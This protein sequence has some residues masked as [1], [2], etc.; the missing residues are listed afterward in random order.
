MFQLNSFSQVDR[1]FIILGL[2]RWPSSQEHWLLFQDTQV[3]AGSSSDSQD[4][5]CRCL[6]LLSQVVPCPF[7]TSTGTRLASSAYTYNH[8][9]KTPRHL[10]CVT[11]FKTRK[12]LSFLNHSIRKLFSHYVFLKLYV[13]ETFYFPLLSNFQTF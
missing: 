2:E 11:E 12:Y 10:K 8:S 9:C 13:E 3:P 5:Y 1:D 4:L 6:Q 7:L